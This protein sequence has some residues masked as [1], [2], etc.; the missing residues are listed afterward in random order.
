MI[1]SEDRFHRYL[2]WLSGAPKVPT[3]T[4]ALGGFPYLI[5]DG[6]VA[7]AYSQLITEIEGLQA[8]AE[9]KEI[10]KLAVTAHYK[11]K[12]EIVWLSRQIKTLSTS[13][14]QSII[15]GVKPENL[16]REGAASYDAVM[17]LIAI[18]G[19][20]PRQYWE[21]C[22]D[23]LGK[24]GTIGIIHLV[25]LHIGAAV[26]SNAVDAPVPSRGELLA[27]EEQ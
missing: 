19:T 3:N 9:V 15:K 24:D 25:G 10:T 27:M 13:Q 17:Y 8:S 7:S 21:N 1:Q 6:T 12:G 18:P 14:V 4:T 2:Q 16:T 22:F 23:T 11:A 5:R 26:I 20:L